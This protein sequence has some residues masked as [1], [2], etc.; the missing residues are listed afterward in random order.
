M[1]FAFFSDPALSTPAGEQVFYQDDAAP[2]AADRL[3]YF[4]SPDAGR[5][6]SVTVSVLAGMPGLAASTVRLALSAAGLD[7][8][9][10]GAALSFELDGGVANGLA[11]YVR[12]L[13]SSGTNGIYTNLSLSADIT[14]AA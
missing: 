2:L 4:G 7:T 5:H 3:V 1:A 13:D 10:P 9:T 11:L 6:A 12:V 8:A 14:E